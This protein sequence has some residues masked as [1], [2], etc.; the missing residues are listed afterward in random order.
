MPL[1]VL[2]F[3]LLVLVVILQIGVIAIVLDKLGLSPHSASLLLF[4][5]FLGSLINLPLFRLR[6]HVP[7]SLE[8]LRIPR[9]LFQSMPLNQHHTT[10][11]LNVGGALIP[12]SFCCY[13]LTS[14][15]LPL[16]AV[17]VNTGLV[18]LVSYLFSRP[19]KN[20]GIGMPMF[21]A[22][23]TAALGAI[24]LAV[25]YSAA[26]A[27]IGGT[28]GVLIGADILRINDIRNMGVPVA[29]IGGAGTF[30]GIFFTGIIAV[31]LA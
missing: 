28:L 25:D 1:I 8:K 10:I 15:Q 23:I 14:Q 13:L 9:L 19:V 6:S 3:I 20:I 26:V 7:V 18:S 16:M 22:P 11:A 27:Y 31:L 4:T 5:T 17:L 2:F 24:L 21:I 12:V 29:S 30:D